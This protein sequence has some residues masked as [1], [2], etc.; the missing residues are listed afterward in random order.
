[1][2]RRRINRENVGSGKVRSEQETSAMEKNRKK[3]TIGEP[4]FSE[5][6]PTERIQKKQEQRKKKR[7]RKKK[8]K[9]YGRD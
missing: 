1:M 5:F 2:K 3:V 9:V 7:R 6:V 4:A 8:R